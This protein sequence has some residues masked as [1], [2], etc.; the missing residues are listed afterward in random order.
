M[1][2]IAGLGNPGT[3]YLGTRHNAGMIIL[4][5]IASKF[6]ISLNRKMFESVYGEG[7]IF[8]QRVVLAMPL[9]YMNLSGRSVKQWL[10][11]YKIAPQDMIVLHDDIDMAEG[12]VKAK[13]G[14]GHGGHNGVRSIIEETGESDFFRIKLGVSKPEMANRGKPEDEIH[15][16]VLGPFT[17][18]QLAQLN[19]AMFEES[20]I[21]LREI[22]LQNQNKN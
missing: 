22:F 16:W 4:E 8:G 10:H 20:L 1:K 15:R 21:R 17:Q 14:G 13:K 3:K 2:L 19:S 9:T 12:A 7:E 5:L 11:F 18:E 6:A